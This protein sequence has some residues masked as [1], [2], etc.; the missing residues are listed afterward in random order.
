MRVA[1]LLF[2]LV[3]CGKH[4]PDCR[5]YATQFTDTVMKGEVNGHPE[6]AYDGSYHECEKGRVSDK[7]YQCVMNAKT[8][9][10]IFV[11]QGLTPP[12]HG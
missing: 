2:L 6:N 3:G 4:G 12:P 10:D 5:A 1:A 8:P 9:D 7:Q 11:C